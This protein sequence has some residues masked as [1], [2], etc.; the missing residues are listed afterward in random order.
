VQHATESTKQN[1]RSQTPGASARQ[2]PA[3][4]PPFHPMLQLQRDI[5][6]QAVLSL[7]R[8]GAI[9]AKLA[10]GSVDDP[11]EKEADSVADKVMRKPS[12]AEAAGGC[13]C[14]A[15]GVMCEECREK[16]RSQTGGPP[17]RRRSTAAAAQSDAPSI[18]RQTLAASGRPLDSAT[19][20]DMERRFAR[21]FGGVRIHADRQAAQS[22]QSI[23]ALAYTFGDNIVFG[24]GQYAP[25]S[26][27]GRRLLANELAHV[28]QQVGEPIRRQADG[29]AGAAPDN[30]PP[31]PA[32]PLPSPSLIDQKIPASG[33]DL[34]KFESVLLSSNPDFVHYQLEQ[35]IATTGLANTSSFVERLASSPASDESSLAKSQ[36][37]REDI[38]KYGS[39]PGG[40]PLAPET[41]EETRHRIA[42]KERVERVIPVAQR[43]FKLLQTVAG[44]F[45]AGFESLANDKMFE[46]LRS[47]QERI[48]GEAKR[49]GIDPS[50]LFVGGELRTTAF[51][52][53]QTP[54]DVV[55]A[56]RGQQAAAAR[57]AAAEKAR[58]DLVKAAIEVRQRR[59]AVERI[60]AQ[61]QVAQNPPSGLLP[62]PRTAF[63]EAKAMQIEERLRK[64]KLQFNEFVAEKKRQ[65]PILAAFMSGG[66]DPT[67]LIDA[68]GEALKAALLDQ[69]NDKLK[70]IFDTRENMRAGKVRPWDIPFVVEGTR[71][72]LKIDKGTMQARVLDDRYEEKKREKIDEKERVQ[73]ISTLSLALGLLA[74]VPTPLSPVLGAAS[75]GLGAY[76]TAHDLD[77][78][79]V[80]S[81]ASRTDFDKALAVSQADPSLLWLAVEII[82]TALD[83]GAATKAL[84]GISSLKRAV[85]AG[86]EGAVQALEAEARKLGPGL[87]ERVV[88]DAEAARRAALTETRTAGK[89]GQ[90]IEEDAVK[91]GKLAE[92][93]FEHGG[94]TYQI[95]KDGR[96]VRCSKWCAELELAFG[97]LFKR[98]PQ[99]AENLKNVR[100]VKGKAAKEAAAG[101]AE[102][103]EQIRKAELMSFE[104]LERLL[105]KPEFATR[106]QGG[107]DLRFVRYQKKG[108]E[109]PFGDWLK[110]SENA[111]EIGELGP[112]TERE[113]KEAY[114]LGPKNKE[115][116][117]PATGEEGFKP[118]H[119]EGAPKGV[120]WG[121]PYHFT[122][123]K[124]WA[125]MSDTGNLSAMLDYVDKVTGSRITIY[126][127]NTTCQVHFGTRYGSWYPMAKRS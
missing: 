21:D 94:H 1:G 39:L 84:Q 27:A 98:Y 19:R 95:L 35:M 119:I 65:F 10:V 47:S 76:V 114:D 90:L 23:D 7:L 109:L 56:A 107:I 16:E 112:R 64:A 102:R 124:D 11:E 89:A 69:I 125:Q 83:L 108:G 31:G 26:D 5:G 62:K 46:M 58:S 25:Q 13:T 100:A 60:E 2:A 106:T 105:D 71:R 40:A 32:A 49:Y 110:K 61:L 3:E 24:E 51:P 9:Q 113:L 18:V 87:A 59:Q 101:L 50:E 75:A 74:L 77:E 93:S 14:A 12:G 48:E 54:A 33:G 44:E 41:E 28:A 82:G 66:A 15:G 115:T 97:D 45:L 29:D 88:A 85:V 67:K 118:D 22:A 120:E 20:G 4:A 103:A 86:E 52:P 38:A 43:E 126:Y 111:W 123:I 99:L 30:P 91:A 78:Y 121:K 34:I 80:Q 57:Y 92:E 70:G 117:K 116:F 72:L 104:E 73:A 79:I 63:D 127:R 55:Q 6:N 96:I 122:E 17:V 37:Q 42:N 68:K 53:A 81:A 8:S 36:L